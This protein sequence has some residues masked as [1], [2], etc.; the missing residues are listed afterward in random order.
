MRLFPTLAQSAACVF[1]LAVMTAAPTFSA[2]QDFV[3]PVARN[4][5]ARVHH[6]LSFHASRPVFPRTFSYQ[7]DTWFNQPRHTRY[8]GPDGKTYWRR[9][10]RGLPIGA[11]APSY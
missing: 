5:R 1:G 8:V 3:P 11:P 6:R 7:Y 10:V 9:T 4:S 2:A